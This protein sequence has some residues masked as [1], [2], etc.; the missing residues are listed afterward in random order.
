MCPF[1]EKKWFKNK[2]SLSNHT[3]WHKWLMELARI[4]I[5]LAKMWD[6][7][8][9]KKEY[10]K[11]KIRKTLM[12]KPKKIYKCFDCGVKVNRKQ[13]KRCKLCDSKSRLWKPNLKIRW[14]NSPKWEWWKTEKH[15]AMRI[16]IEYKEWHRMVLKR[17]NY[18]CVICNAKNWNWKAIKLECDHIKP[19]STH[20]HLIY[21]IDNWRTLCHD[22]HV[23]TP[24]YWK[25][26]FNN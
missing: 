11:E 5:K 19:V 8:P 21:D 16:S 2:K 24:T 1:C 15:R 12:S 9:A 18:A 23:K 26:L 14:E 7:N 6:K 10:V 22:C 25:K 13:T 4:N 17:D 3:R 20:P